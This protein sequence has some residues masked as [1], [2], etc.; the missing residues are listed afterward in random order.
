MIVGGKDGL[1][2][3]IKLLQTSLI[4]Q[5][6]FSHIVEHFTI[7]Q[8]SQCQDVI[9]SLPT[10]SKSLAKP[11]VRYRLYQIGYMHSQE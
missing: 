10:T 1:G 9:V 11:N 3:N 8:A 4:E 2:H 5:S 6:I 7:V